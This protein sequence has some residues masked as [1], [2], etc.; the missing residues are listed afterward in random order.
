ML[1]GNKDP[2]TDM[3]RDTA[4]RCDRGSVERQVHRMTRNGLTHASRTL[5]DG[6][7]ERETDSMN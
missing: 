6:W 1:T 2:G 4:W 7:D 5:I 3:I